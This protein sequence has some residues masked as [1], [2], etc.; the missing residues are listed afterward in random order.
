MLGDE[1]LLYITMLLHSSKLRVAVT[2]EM[3]V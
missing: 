2:M 3:F 1:K